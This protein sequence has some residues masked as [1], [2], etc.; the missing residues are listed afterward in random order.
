M[1]LIRLTGYKNM[2]DFGKKLY[3]LR[4]KKDISQQRLSELSSYTQT[5]ISL[6]ETGKIIPSKRCQYA[7]ISSLEKIEDK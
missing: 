3:E 6:V 7:L 4:T 1:S 5:Y 2:K